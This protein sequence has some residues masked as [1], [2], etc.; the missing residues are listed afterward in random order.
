MIKKISEK[1]FQSEFLRNIF[2]L[3]SGTTIAQIL[4]I[5]FTPVLTRLYSPEAYS[6]LGEFVAQVSV[7]SV[8]LVLRSEYALLL[9]K[10]ED[11]A[12]RLYQNNSIILILM[13]MLC[14][15]AKLIYDA[16]LLYKSQ[17]FFV[18]IIAFLY[19]IAQGL[20]L[21]N[22]FY[23]NRHKGYKDISLSKILR[24][25]S[26][27]VFSFVFSILDSE[28]GLVYAFT[29]GTILEGVVLCVRNKRNVV[30][31]KWV[32]SKDIFVKFKKFPLL[33]SPSAIIH[34]LSIQIPLF[35][36]PLFYDENQ[37]GQYYQALRL[38][39]IPIT[40]IATAIGQVYFKELSVCVSN[41]Q[42]Y[43]LTRKIVIRTG[44][45]GLFIFVPVMFT[46][47]SLLPIILGEQWSLTGFFVQ[48]LSVYVAV[49]LMTSSISSI[50]NV[51]QKQGPALLSNIIF[52]I[53]KIC[54][55][56]FGG[57]IMP[58]TKLIALFSIISFGYYIIILLY[59]MRVVRN[60]TL[61]LG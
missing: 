22:S 35:I 58:I 42:A 14:L 30:G 39:G 47:K 45:V 23:L 19:L 31:F 41:Q 26:I 49:Q 28:N 32:F 51:Y 48:W 29:L 13:S 57:M 36:L 52:L 5:L 3:M 25:S 33:D 21:N 15:F 34:A 16:V 56:Y 37:V 44:V 38:V 4:P 54:I 7:L 17:Q 6:N 1:W 11:D 50:F 18:Y 12:L 53:V 2:T 24:A 10:E 27:L 9:P 59:Q 20:V 8:I 43:E 60:F 46:S 55:L 61:K 40:F